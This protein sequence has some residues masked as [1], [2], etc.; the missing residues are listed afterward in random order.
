[1]NTKTHTATFKAPKAKV[2]AYLSDTENLPEWATGFCKSL[3]KDGD[4][5]FVQTAE[6]ELYFRID[7]DEKTGVIDMA[8]G[9]SKDVAITWPIRVAPLPDDSTLLT[10][11]ALQLPGV[12]DEV[13]AGQCA[14]LEREFENIRTAVE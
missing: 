2:F 9:P 11:T 6:C 12:S 4:D 8:S 10:F 14:E 1:M 7:H 13:F 3:R 5:Y